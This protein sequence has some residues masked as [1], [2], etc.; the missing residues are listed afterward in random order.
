MLTRSKNEL[1]ERLRISEF[2]NDLKAG[3]I[4]KMADQVLEFRKV[5]E[6]YQKTVDIQ[7]RQINYQLQQIKQYEAELQKLKK[8]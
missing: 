3:H 6:D 5:A 1:S 8:R 2:N 4:D 7:H